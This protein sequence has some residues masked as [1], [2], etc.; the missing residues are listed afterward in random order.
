VKN[1]VANDGILAM[2]GNATKQIFQYGELSA[3]IGSGQFT[4]YNELSAGSGM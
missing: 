3:E 4:Q 1:V 2:L